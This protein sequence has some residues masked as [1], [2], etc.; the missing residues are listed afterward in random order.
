MAAAGGTAAVL[1]AAA[2]VLCCR[3]KPGFG[4]GDESDP[5]LNPN[6]LSHHSVDRP[7]A[8][9]GGRPYTNIGNDGND[10]NDGNGNSNATSNATSTATSNGTSNGTG[11]RKRHCGGDGGKRRG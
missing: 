9:D 8:G 1:C 6:T 10:G 3:S 11:I 5:T 4:A 2:M 7:P